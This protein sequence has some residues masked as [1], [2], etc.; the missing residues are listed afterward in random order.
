MTH[1]SPTPAE[2]DGMTCDELLAHAQREL[3]E[4]PP[5]SPHA[6]NLI[7]G[8]NMLAHQKRTGAPGIFWNTAGGN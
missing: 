2:L 1:V 4:L 6:G 7:E 5:E 8:F 3:A